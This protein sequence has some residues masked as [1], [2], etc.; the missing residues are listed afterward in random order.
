MIVYIFLLI[1]EI[2]EKAK[3]YDTIFVEHGIYKENIVIRK[4]LTIIG[5]NYP[6]IDGENKREIIIIESDDVQII[7]FE[8]INSGFSEIYEISAV[9]VKNSKNCKILN[10][11]LRNNFFGIYLE[12]V[13]GCEIKNNEIKNEILK[14][15]ALMGNGIHSWK[16]KNLLIENNIIYGHRDGIYLEF[17]NHSVIRNNKSYYNV[18]YGLHFMFSKEIILENCIFKNNK[19]GTALMYSSNLIIKNNEFIENV[20]TSNY[21]LLLKEIKNS[22]FEKNKFYENTSG[23]YIENSINNIFFSNE[24]KRN[25]FAIRI[26]ANCENNYFKRNL[27][28]DNLFELLTN[29]IT[30]FNNKFLRNYWD[31]YIGY[32]RNKDKIGDEPYRIVKISSFLFENYEISIILLNSPFLSFLEL[33]EKLIPSISP[34]IYDYEPLLN[35][36]NS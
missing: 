26:M 15:E 22:N 27:F 36:G 2:I 25:K 33:I 17:V 32:D 7:G 9:K 35:Y 12:N 23:V 21:G 8:I 11:K 3:P 14:T 19:G 24:F 6:V 29:S 28:I 31:K 1:S 16:S 5:K 30:T 13:N 20:G 18:R 34:N 4:P 10:N